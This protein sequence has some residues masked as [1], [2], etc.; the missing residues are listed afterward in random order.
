MR[1]VPE[2]LLVMLTGG[3]PS[4]QRLL[5]EAAAA[6]VHVNRIVFLQKVGIYL[7]RSNRLMKSSL[8]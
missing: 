8:W 5:A 1:R 6:G 7:A 2:A 4:Q 3:L